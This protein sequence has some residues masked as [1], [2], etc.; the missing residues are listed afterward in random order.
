MSTKHLYNTPNG[1]VLKSLRGAVRLN[2]SLRLHAP[3]KCIYTPSPSPTAT[4]SVISG[5]GA[6]HEP[7]HASYT[8]KG[9][10]TASVSGDIFASPSAKQIL[11]TLQLASYSGT[12]DVLVII[13]NYTGDRLNFGLGIE[14]ARA[15]LPMVR[16]ESVVVADDVSLLHH[17]ESLVGPRGLAGNILVCKILGALAERGAPLEV[18][19][20]LGDAVVANLASIGVG[21]EHCHVPGREPSSALGMEECEVGLGLHN[22]PGVS[23]LRMG[24]VEEL[25]SRM[26]GLIL[27]SRDAAGLGVNS[28]SFIDADAD[29]GRE[30]VV[31]FVNNLGGMS[32]L[33]M[34]AVLDEISCQLAALGI[35]PRRTYLSTYMT[36]L[37][38]P[39]FSISLLNT[40]AVHR[41]LSQPSSA[42]IDVLT[43]LDD[44]TDATA[45][46]GVRVWPH[47]I[48]PRDLAVESEEYERLDGEEEEVYEEGGGKWD[49]STAIVKAALRGACRALLDAEKELTEYDTVVG[50]GDCGG[51][52]ASGARGV[53]EA[54]D[55]GILPLSHPSSLLR[56]IA[57]ISEDTMGGTIGALFGIYFTALSSSLSSHPS[58]SS[59]SPWPTS[60]PQALHALSTH[61]PAREGDRTLMDALIPFTHAVSLGMSLD[62][63]VRAARGMRARLGRTVYV[64]GGGIEEGGEGKEGEGEEKGR[65]VPD[66]GAWGV[67]C[68]LEGMLG[69]LREVKGGG[70]IN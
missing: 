18:I 58:P 45:W 56:K 7:A 35:H 62:A 54:L 67:I 36:S 22:E 61:T 21:L 10:L 28:T 68:A 12:R 51:T 4:V 48:S 59:S 8:G 37:N 44:P 53:L 3:S 52:L 1:L 50:D 31:L 47:T 42:P 64:L 38:A 29:G 43:L 17:S 2:P 24:S 70:G 5:G 32:Q 11:S 65:R 46:I 13:N 33:E 39:G 26:L 16:I 9:M 60:L 63:A 19:K 14:K 34:G 20:D 49:V 30:D 23:R 66:P 69:G 6:G 27:G 15:K 40:S 55:S 25:V 41:Q 57:E